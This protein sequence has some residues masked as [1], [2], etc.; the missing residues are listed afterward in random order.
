MVP[1]LA[2]A[3]RWAWLVFKSCCCCSGCLPPTAKLPVNLRAL[4]CVLDYHSKLLH[5][6][7]MFIDVHGCC[8]CR[9]PSRAPSPPAA[10]ACGMAS[11]R[12]RDGDDDQDAA[13]HRRSVRQRRPIPASSNHL[14]KRQRD[15]T[16]VKP[17]R[18]RPRG[19]PTTDGTL[20]RTRSQADTV[21]TQGTKRQR[22]DGT[23]L[24]PARPE[25]SRRRCGAGREARAAPP[26]NPD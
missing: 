22:V 12:Q 13:H 18:L 20:K 16:A 2:H 25:D 26:W 4:L 14:A 11:P 23:T 9:A 19:L 15:A 10:P 24:A 5:F 8:R 21:G 1:P 3:A 7:L 17:R 6:L